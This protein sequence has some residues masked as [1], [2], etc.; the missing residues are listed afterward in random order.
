MNKEKFENTENYSVNK[1]KALD[2][3]QTLLVFGGTLLAAEG[4]INKGYTD[5]I[6][7]LIIVA[8]SSFVSLE[9]KPKK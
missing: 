3:A 6:A 8:V 1:Q 4:V 9:N 7:G 2:A 5:I